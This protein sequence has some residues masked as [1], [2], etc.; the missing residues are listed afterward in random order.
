MHNDALAAAEL[1]HITLHG[2]RRSFGTLSEW[3]EVPVRVVAQIQGRKPSTSAEKHYRR[4]P[5]DLLRMTA[6]KLG[7]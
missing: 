7:F 4:L 5:I 2:L 1:P 6:S 3:G